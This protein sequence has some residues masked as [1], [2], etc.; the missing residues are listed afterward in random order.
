L[1][2]DTIHLGDVIDVKHGFAFKSAYFAD[3]GELVLLSPGNCY[4]AGGLKLK[5]NNE[6]YYT[7]EVPPEFLLSEGDMLVVMTDL[8]NTAPILGGSFVIPEDD[9]FLHNQRLGLVEI[10]DEHRIDQSFLYYLLNSYDYRAQVRGSAS[11]ATVR[12]TSPG[13]IKDCSVRIPRDVRHQQHIAAVLSAY[14]NLI[15]NT[16]RRMA[17]LEEAV[18]QIYREWFVRR[19]FPGYEHTPVSEGVPRGWEKTNALEAMSVLSGGTPKTAVADYWNGDIPF[20]TPK[21]ANDA[22]YVLETDR[23]ITELGLK[24]CNSRLYATD[25]VFISA[26]GTVGKLR[27]ACRP[28]A[29]S[30][31]CYALVGKGHISQFFL[32]SA[33][34]E[35]IEYLKQ[36]AGGAVF[37]A[38]IVDTFKRIPFMVPDSRMVRLFEETV[39]PMFRQV[40]NLL[41]QNQKLRTAREV[42]LPRLMSGEIAV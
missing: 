19:R 31:S 2:W 4:E 10:K 21:D 3:A 26:R 16:R 30:Q 27:L 9:R 12:H 38:I 24:N 36:H 35:S 6:K 13:R 34:Q 39:A 28:M 5:G 8:I 7:G 40:A 42:L 25:T 32:Y 14:D 18:R 33:L 1:T 37:D 29:M 22:C 20:Y 11:G 15:E 23:G 17:L 41:E